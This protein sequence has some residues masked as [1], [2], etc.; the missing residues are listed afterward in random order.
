MMITGG[1][2]GGNIL[3]GAGA[4]QRCIAA[5]HRADNCRTQRKDEQKSHKQNSSELIL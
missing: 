2:T 4:A 5:H 1:A 3:I